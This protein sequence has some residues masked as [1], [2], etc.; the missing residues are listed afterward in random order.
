VE[1]FY[2]CPASHVLSQAPENT[3][4]AA[5]GTSGHK[6]LTDSING[7]GPR[8]PLTDELTAGIDNVIAEAAYVVNVKARTSR[9][10][11]CDI[12]RN[13]GPLEP[14][15]VP[16]SLDVQGTKNETTV[17]VRDWK[18][19]TYSSVW[20]LVVQ[21][22]AVLYCDKGRLT[23]VVD[24]GFTYLDQGEKPRHELYLFGRMELDEKAD[25]LVHAFDRVKAVYAI[26][27]KGLI[28]H[29]K[30]GPWCKYCPSRDVCPAKWAMIR[31]AINES[32]EL[33]QSEAI[34]ALTTEQCGEAWVKLR[35][36][37]KMVEKAKETLSGRL[38]EG[39]FPLPNG[40]ELSLVRR[41]GWAY[42]NKDKALALLEELGATEEQIGRI[43]VMR[44]DTFAATERKAK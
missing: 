39:P 8:L 12:G 7:T 14:Y 13:Y 20:Q 36:L 4:Q 37:E 34:M 17:W 35:D 41:R 21:A 38:E 28:P 32:F 9:F 29:V 33:R 40:K 44:P 23:S 5:A 2:E 24:A 22:M 6:P 30:Q 18:F 26:V 43:M 10:I 3:K 31:S 27:R 11:G 42:P 16:V 25:E 15:D 19:G 1:C